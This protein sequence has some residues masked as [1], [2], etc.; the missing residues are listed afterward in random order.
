MSKGTLRISLDFEC[1]W[2]CVSDGIWHQRQS[3]GIYRDLRPALA[4]FTKRADDLE[5]KLCWAVVGAMI[6]PPS[7][8]D[9]AHLRG[10]YALDIRRFNDEAEEPTHDGRDLLDMVTSMQTAQ[11]FGTHTYSHLTVSDPEQGAE[12]LAEDL[13]RAV[14][15]NAKL[16]LDADR[17][18]FPRNHYGHF[19]VVRSAGIKCA[20][21][22]PDNMVDPQNRPGP[23]KRAISGI[24]RPVSPVTELQDES[25]VILH[26]ATEFLNW[27]GQSGVVKRRLQQ[28][29]INRALTQASN[30]TDV[31]FWL[32]PFNLV[33]TS[34]L[35]DF[36]DQFL[37]QIA[38]Y[39]DADR[40]RVTG[41]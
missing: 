4:R 19:D 34:G 25:G 32:H 21:M 31:H 39:R 15:V 33:E 37:I 20:R 23:I 11:Q 17:L 26:H 10:K 27:G 38:K 30:G 2:G 1:G 12:V 18:V 24:L 5:L 35:G 40:L 14:Y 29:R 13:S 28:R 6:E 8:R 41:F 16:G 7:E 3:D 22:P 9:F 36:V